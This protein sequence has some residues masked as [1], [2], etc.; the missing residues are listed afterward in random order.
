MAI[1][2]TSM[3]DG[4]KYSGLVDF[5]K[6]SAKVDTQEAKEALVFMFVCMN[7]KWKIPVGY[8]L[9]NGTSAEQKC[10]LIMDYLRELHTTG[11]RVIA[12]TCDG[13]N[14]ST[15]NKLGC[16]TTLHSLKS[17]FPH[18][19]TQDKVFAFLDPCH[20]I[21]LI[22][23]VFGYFKNLRDGLS[24]QPINWNYIIKLHELQ[25]HEMLHLANKFRASH[26]YYGKQKMKVRFAT[27]LFSKSVAQAL[28]VCR[29]I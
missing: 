5:G 11:A 29:H 25:K 15:L 4:D 13:A 23:N 10:A 24:H 1:R 28:E 7:G 27:Q 22:R 26:I 14:V 19:V 9:V 21:K 18:P 3:P 12:I 8:F 20:M 6:N 16:N 2:R 17:Y